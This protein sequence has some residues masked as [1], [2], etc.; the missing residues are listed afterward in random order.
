MYNSAPPKINRMGGVRPQGYGTPNQLH[1]RT[2]MGQ[3]YRPGSVTAVGNMNPAGIQF[4]NPMTGFGLG[5]PFARPQNY[6]LQQVPGVVP[7][8]NPTPR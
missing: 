1:T 5:N 2:Q 6:G 4:Q 3:L 8:F 7:P